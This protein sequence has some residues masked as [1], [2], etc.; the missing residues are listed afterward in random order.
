MKNLPYEL[1]R[2]FEK[3]DDTVEVELSK[4]IPGTPHA[5]I[6]AN[7][8]MRLAYDGKKAK[9]APIT[10]V[11][12]PSGEYKV[13]DGNST[14]MN[15]AAYDWPTIYVRV[16]PYSVVEGNLH[17]MEHYDFQA[18]FDTRWEAEEYVD[19]HTEAADLAG[20]CLFIE[21]FIGV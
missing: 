3:T 4:L 11:M 1:D 6:S 18:A 8:F 5:A 16:K 9:R 7:R 20:V 13:L 14:L 21:K 2:Y 10:V 15:A 19:E 12:L 17:D